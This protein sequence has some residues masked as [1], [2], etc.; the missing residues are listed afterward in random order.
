[1][2]LTVGDSTNLRLS[3]TIKGNASSSSGIR[4]KENSGTEGGCVD[5]ETVMVVSVSVVEKVCTVTVTV[6]WLVTVSVAVEV[7]VTVVVVGTV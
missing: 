3:R 6:T 4:P 1:M 2:P 5:V 7:T